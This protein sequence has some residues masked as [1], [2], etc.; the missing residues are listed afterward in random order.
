MSFCRLSSPCV[1]MWEVSV[2]PRSSPRRKAPISRRRCLARSTTPGKLRRAAGRVGRSGSMAPPSKRS[3]IPEAKRTSS[4]RS[5]SAS[6]RFRTTSVTPAS[7]AECSAATHPRRRYRISSMPCGPPGSSRSPGTN[8][9]PCGPLRCHSGLLRPPFFAGGR[10]AAGGAAGWAAGLA[11]P[12]GCGRAAAGRAAGCFWT[13]FGLTG[14]RAV[15]ARA[16][17]PPVRL[18]FLAVGMAS[19]L[20]QELLRLPG[21]LHGEDRVKPRGVYHADGAPPARLVSAP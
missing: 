6:P 18:F 7:P 12:L 2:R 13:A 19:P 11:L 8:G 15:L 20:G 16:L 21:G 10:A 1:S 4:P 3:A 14:V 17:W 9:S 5:A